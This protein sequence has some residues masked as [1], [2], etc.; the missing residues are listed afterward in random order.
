MDKC[1]II[2]IIIIIIINNNIIIIRDF[3]LF[4]AD[5]K[6]RDCPDRCASATNT[7]S[8]GSGIFRGRSV[9]FNDLLPGVLIILFNDL[10][11]GC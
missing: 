8:R 5:V 4:H 10:L 9:L 11:P 1:P 6:R 2:I 7:I 3:N